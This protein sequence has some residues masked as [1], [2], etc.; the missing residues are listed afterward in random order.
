MGVVS[1]DVGVVR[2]GVGV[3]RTDVEA[4]GEEDVQRWE[5]VSLSNG[6]DLKCPPFSVLVEDLKWP[7]SAAADRKLP[8]SVEAKGK[9]DNN[10]KSKLNKDTC[11]STMLLHSAGKT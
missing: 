2:P 10:Q 5:P 4:S 6:E 9:D 3:V 11:Y 7:P 8:A 1:P